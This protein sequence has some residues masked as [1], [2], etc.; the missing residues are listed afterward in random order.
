[1]TQ[2]P[3]PNIFTTSHCYHGD[4]RY[5]SEME[6]NDHKVEQCKTVIQ[7]RKRKQHMTDLLWM[8]FLSSKD[9]HS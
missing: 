1:M 9:D 8:Q 7:H 5:S 2:Q 3:S 4:E 6:G